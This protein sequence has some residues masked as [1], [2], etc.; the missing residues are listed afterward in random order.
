[1]LTCN[2][3]ATAKGLKIREYQDDKILLFR[4]F[5]N[6]SIKNDIALGCSPWFRP[7]P[8]AALQTGLPIVAD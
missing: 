3:K 4:E 8:L 7:P 6:V 1:V 5:A 2:A